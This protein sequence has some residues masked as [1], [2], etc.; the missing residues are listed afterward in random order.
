[1]GWIEDVSKAVTDAYEVASDYI[2]SGGSAPSFGGGIAE[3]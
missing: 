3:A 2:S 1:M